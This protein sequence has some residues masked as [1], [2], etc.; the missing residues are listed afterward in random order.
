[1]KEHEGVS[2]ELSREHV[3]QRISDEWKRLNK[4]C[5][6]L[7]QSSASFQKGAVNLA[8][9]VPLMYDYDHHSSLPSLG[10]YMMSKFYDPK[11]GTC[12]QIQICD[13]PFHL[14]G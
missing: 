2:V 13:D 7:N 1:M 5:L 12:K 6:S 3:I 4:E 10:E 9:M 14:L 8:R 11:A